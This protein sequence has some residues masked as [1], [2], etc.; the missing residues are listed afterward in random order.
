MSRR[1]VYQSNTPTNT[2]SV[3]S[4]PKLAMVRWSARSLSRADVA[5]PRTATTAGPM[6]SSWRHFGSL[7]S[8][9]ATRAPSATNCSVTARPIPDPPPTTSATLPS[10]QPTGRALRRSARLFV[11]ELRHERPP[12]QAVVERRAEVRQFGL[13]AGIDLGRMGAE[14]RQL[15]RGFEQ[16][17]EVDRR[18]DRGLDRRAGDGDAVTA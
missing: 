11:V 12:G 15:H 13:V 10:S 7:I 17:I 18:D 14:P 2:A 9:T 5:S 4:R 8:S 16:H 3:S 1:R 6:P